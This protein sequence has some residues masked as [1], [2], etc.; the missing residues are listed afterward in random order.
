MF[1]F[2]RSLVNRME[3][4]SSLAPAFGFNDVSFRSSSL[5]CYTKT[6]LIALLIMFSHVAL[7]EDY[8]VTLGGDDQNSGRSVLLAWKTLARANQ[9]AFLPGDRLLLEAA[10]DFVGPLRLI[11]IA[12]SKDH[13]IEV[14]THFVGKQR[15]KA[16]ID[17]GQGDTALA[18]INVSHVKISHLSLSATIPVTQQKT[19][20]SASKKRMRIG[21]LVKARR[22]GNF[23]NIVLDD[24]DIRDVFY[25]Q[26]GFS[27]DE[28]EVR[29][30]NGTQNY[31]WGIRVINNLKNATIS[32]LSIVNSMIQNV[33]HTGIK[34]SGREHNITNVSVTNNRVINIGGP[35]I[36]LSGVKQGYFAHNQVDRSGSNDDSRKWGRGSGLWTWGSREILVERNRFTNAQGPADSAGV[37]IDYNCSDVIVQFNYSANN[38]GGFY[39]VLGN[40]YNTAYRYN[41]SV[42]DGYRVKGK[43]GAFQQGKTFWLSGYNG[44]KKARVGPFNSYFYNNTIF[45]DED[46]VSSVAIDQGAA[47]ILIA[48]NIFHIVT[49]AQYVRGDQYRPDTS[50]GKKIVNAFFKNNLFLHQQSWPAEAPIQDSQPSFGDVKF[51]NARGMAIEDFRPQNKLLVKDMG[52]V[53]TQLVNDDKGLF[54]GLGV[55][56]DILGQPIVG[57]PDLGAIELQHTSLLVPRN[58]VKGD[59]KL[60][61]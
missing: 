61:K 33:S 56:H 28:A 45:L 49:K 47:G 43:N 3:Q 42:N 25:H 2:I 22:P 37:H 7:S 18:L 12:G 57:K 48:N 27:R 34:F 5:I 46:I 40:N 4:S 17:A 39:E 31:G 32:G 11:N 1:A 59:S 30:A 13:P 20:G 52:M 8:Y 26:A 10:Q 36:Q 24:L 14:S 19:K 51:A 35:G 60:G 38:A 41:I 6:L 54:L 55:T 53:V 21:V 29:T 23:T 16:H 58:L 50:K 9:H 44:Q 15:K